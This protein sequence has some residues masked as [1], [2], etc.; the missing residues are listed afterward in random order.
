[1]RQ[2]ALFHYPEFTSL[3]PLIHQAFAKQC[4]LSIQYTQILTS[5]EDF[6]AVL[7]QFRQNEG[8]G[9]NVT[10]P[11][12][13][14]AF[15]LCHKT[16]VRAQQA[17]SVN[18]LYWE[19][20][21]LC[22]DTTDG[23]GFIQGLNCYHEINKTHYA[24]RI[25][26]H[27]FFNQNPFVF[28]QKKVLLLGAGGAAAA[29][30]NHIIAQNPHHIYIGNRTIEKGNVLRDRF[31]QAPITVIEYRDLQEEMTRAIKDSALP[32]FD[33]II[34]A[35]SI[36]DPKDFILKR[37]QIK[38]VHFYDLNYSSTHSLSPLAQWA[39]DNGSAYVIDGLKMLIAQAAASFKIWHPDECLNPQD[40]DVGIKSHLES[41][42]N[43]ST[44]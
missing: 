5:P 32:A 31:S 21:K 23:E 42:G 20:D 22:G 11:L 6:P 30:L 17:Q 19:G 3:S 9:A 13:T 33:W 18:T 28:Q 14:I 44:T 38:G 1:M 36:R 27:H 43:P 24:T 15:Q 16:T 10:K 40:V 39:R 2:Y 34:N 37:E 35:T 41:L 7:Q 25:N 8:M 12:K 29:I 26:T 4:Q